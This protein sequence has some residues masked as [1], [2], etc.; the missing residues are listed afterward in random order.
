MSK[1]L[2]YN[3]NRGTW[4][5][6]DYDHATDTLIIHTK[7]DLQPVLDLAKEERNSGINDKVGDF[8]KYAYIPAHVEVEL[9][10]KG[11]NIYDQN[12][13]AELLREINQNYSYL[14]TTNLHHEVKAS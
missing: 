7:Q 14:K 12:Q 8:G 4:Y 5:E 10:K 3:A 9:R 2:D 6:E 13:T 11:I 1:F